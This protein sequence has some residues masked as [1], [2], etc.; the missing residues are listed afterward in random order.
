MRNIKKGYGLKILL[1][2]L[3]IILCFTNVVYSFSEQTLRVP[4]SLQD[5][6]VIFY[7]KL[8]SGEEVNI[9][10][11]TR[12]NLKRY[13]NSILKMPREETNTAQSRTALCNF[14]QDYI[15]NSITY[16]AIVDDEV[17]GLCF[18]IIKREKGWFKNSKSKKEFLYLWRF[19]VVNKYRNQGIGN[20]F[21]WLIADGAE[22]KNISTIRVEAEPEYAADFLWKRGFRDDR[23]FVP[24]YYINLK[25]KVSVVK[26]ILRKIGKSNYPSRDK[27]QLNL[28][29]NFCRSYI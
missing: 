6:N 12:R 16:I 5:A 22:R 26:K 14:L 24:W 3:S 18:S 11:L 8:S 21:L 7:G 9:F 29:A 28:F 1:L 17:I 25:A 23:R 15:D 13:I 19:E 20:I 2:K 4:L 10:Q 27:R